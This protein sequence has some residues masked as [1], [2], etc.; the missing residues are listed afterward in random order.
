MTVGKDVNLKLLWIVI[1]TNAQRILM[2]GCIAGDFLFG[3]FNVTLDCFCGW[4]FGTLINSMRGYP[5][6]R[7]TGNSAW[8]HARKS[9]RHPPQ[10]CP[11]P[12]GDLD[13]HLIHSNLGPPDSKWNLNR[14]SCSCGALGHY[15]QTDRPYY[16]VC[17]NR[18][19]NR[20]NNNNICISL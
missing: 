11:F 18:S 5:D 13:P 19:N 4:S 8:R 1:I 12:C 3:K 2:R 17:N 15:R 10:K 16:S 9:Q 14:F 20:N 7:A 6:T